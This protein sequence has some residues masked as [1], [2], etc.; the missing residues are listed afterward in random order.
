M[1]RN[2]IKKKKKLEKLYLQQTFTKSYYH[3][4]QGLMKMHETNPTEKCTKDGE[5][6]E[7]PK[8]LV[9]LH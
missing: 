8:N 4:I 9:K 1:A 6:R 2:P 5:K 3:N 7:I